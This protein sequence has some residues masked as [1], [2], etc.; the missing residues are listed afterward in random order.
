MVARH[1]AGHSVGRQDAV[2]FRGVVAGQGERRA[3]LAQLRAGPPLGQ[4]PRHQALHH[5]HEWP[6]RLANRTFRLERLVEVV[7]NLGLHP[8][9]RPC[10]VRRVEMPR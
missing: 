6:G 7:R 10:R 3:Q 8:T 4:H 9:P 2:F 1:D 5:L